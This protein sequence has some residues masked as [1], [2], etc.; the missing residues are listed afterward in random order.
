MTNLPPLPAGLSYTLIPWST[1]ELLGIDYL[2]VRDA[3]Q[4]VL[5]RRESRPFDATVIDAATYDL[6]EAERRQAWEDRAVAGEAFVEGLKADDADLRSSARAK[7]IAGTPLTEEE[8]A[9]IT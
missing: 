3:D 4:E 6:I 8:A 7:L 9:A 5:V 1:P 2:I